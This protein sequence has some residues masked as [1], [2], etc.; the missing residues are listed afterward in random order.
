MSPGEFY[1]YFIVHNDEKENDIHIHFER[2][3]HTLY[4]LY[5]NLTNLHGDHKSYEDFCKDIWPYSWDKEIT[6]KPD[7]KI[8]RTEEDWV[9]IEKELS[10][11]TYDKVL[12]DFSEVIATNKQ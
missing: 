10:S 11:K 3:R 7:I 12:N 8:E 9:N 1:S 6:R 5:L 2:N 4:F